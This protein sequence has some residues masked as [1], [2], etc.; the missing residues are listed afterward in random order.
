M[1]SLLHMPDGVCKFLGKLAS[2]ALIHYDPLTKSTYIFCMTDGV[3]VV[4]M[5]NVKPPWDG[6]LLLPSQ[7]TS[8]LKPGY[9]NVVDRQ[10]YKL[11]QVY[12]S[13]DGESGLSIMYN[14]YPNISYIRPAEYVSLLTNS[15][16][17]S[18]VIPDEIIDMY[19]I[20]SQVGSTI[21]RA[22]EIRDGMAYMNAK[23]V[24]VVIRDLTHNN[25]A[26]SLTKGK[27]QFINLFKP[28][29]IK[30]R[31]DGKQVVLR[32]DSSGGIS[33]F[34][35]FGKM[36]TSSPPNLKV[37][38]RQEPIFTSQATFTTLYSMLA[39]LKENKHIPLILRVD[40]SGL[41]SVRQGLVDTILP[42]AMANR[43]TVAFS[44]DACTFKKCIAKVREV[45]TFS[46][47]KDKFTIE[48]GKLLIV[49]EVRIEGFTKQTTDGLDELA[50]TLAVSQGE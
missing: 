21:N 35:I 34:S 6:D 9:Y 45:C 20:V 28:S 2:D 12:T 15:N 38:D 18:R 8:N 48:A 42:V 23:G 1:S 41:C 31:V 37:L 40:T 19:S 17:L 30:V 13:A 32:H 22:I 36:T 4:T 27:M 3:K 39:T 10:D 14:L 26:F 25:V 46:V 24:N 50:N 49:G 44:V 47:Y 5:R 16:Y 33:Y 43:P 11:V 29:N 7:V